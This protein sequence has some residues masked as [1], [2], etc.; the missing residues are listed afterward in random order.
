MILADGVLIEQNRV[1]FRG[2]CAVTGINIT[3][4][5]SS[6]LVDYAFVIEIKITDYLL[7][8]LLQNVRVDSS[9]LENAKSVFQSFL[10]INIVRSTAAKLNLRLA[11]RS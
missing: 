8:V 10:K 3:L 5:R 6:S 1:K 7:I 2:T 11:L 9:R 4:L